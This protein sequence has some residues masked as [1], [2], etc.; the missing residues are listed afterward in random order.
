MK[1]LAWSLAIVVGWLAWA[2]STAQAQA[3]AVTLRLT[4]ATVRLAPGDSAEARLLL[5]NPTGAAVRI[6][7]APAI[8]G[9]EGFSLTGDLPAA[10]ATIAAGATGVWSVRIA[11]ATTAPSAGSLWV[12][13]DYAL[14]AAD[15]KETPG[16]LLAQLDVQDRPLESPDKL[17][18]VRV[19]SA[20]EQIQDGRDGMVQVIVSNL[21]NGPLTLSGI[22]ATPDNP[23]TLDVHVDPAARGA[24]LI[25]Q[26]T[27]VF[28]ATVTALNRVQPGKQMITFEAQ[29]ER[30][31]GAT[32][33]RWSVVATFK[34]TAGVFGAS[35][36]LTVL[37]VPSLLLLPGFLMLVAF[38][39]FWVRLAPRQPL[40]LDVKSADFWLLAVCL[41][42][43]FALA[44]PA[45]TAGLGD[46][47]DYLRVYGLRD[48][49][50]VW[51]GSAAT[52][53]AVWFATAVVLKRWF[54]PME[55]DKPLTI[56]EKLRRN[57]MNTE[58]LEVEVELGAPAPY[59]AFV[60]YPRGEAKN[61]DGKATRW[62]VPPMEYV[63]QSAD[64]GFRSDFVAKMQG[65]DMPSFV[66]FVADGAERRWVTLRWTAKGELQGPRA[67]TD[68]QIKAIHGRRWLLSDA[69]G[70]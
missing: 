23:G 61:S 36:V 46:P 21:T 38:R 13:L 12:Q 53:F 57:G 3:P 68:S 33:Q 52:G 63:F 14:V 19:D 26:Q 60:A 42:F 62:I 47:R 34:L 35:E 67:V 64:A 39:F 22:T 5:A 28:S 69:T 24:T 4:P 58:L 49:I 50:N 48:V 37:G 27:R 56:L 2:C 29:F 7:A 70:S 54:V 66:E 51:I 65:S 15:G 9:D 30:P 17:V 31:Q 11:R 18:S 1:R 10:G 59:R 6:K 44:Y 16:I 32:V 20:L 40:D 8:F 25:A 43:A 45:V 41:S 55:R